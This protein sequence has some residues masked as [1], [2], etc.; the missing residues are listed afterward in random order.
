MILSAGEMVYE[1]A[2]CH[3]RQNQHCEILQQICCGH[4]IRLL[5]SKTTNHVSLV[6]GKE[7][8]C[9]QISFQNRG[10]QPDPNRVVLS[11]QLSIWENI[12][13]SWLYFCKFHVTHSAKISSFLHESFNGCC[14]KQKK[15]GKDFPARTCSFLVWKWVWT[16]N[17]SKFSDQRQNPTKFAA[18]CC[19]QL[20][21]Q[22]GRWHEE[23]HISVGRVLHKW[24]GVLLQ[25]KQVWKL[26]HQVLS[27][28]SKHMAP[29]GGR[30]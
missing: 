30:K 5:K 18:A 8:V 3:Q 11:T 12:S 2:R 21:H 13:F 4:W 14:E 27:A 10:I 1:A 25:G 26:D 29:P 17:L 23:G 20:G 7:H 28:S 19:Q 6:A 24:R 22:C 16:A 15:N 9:C